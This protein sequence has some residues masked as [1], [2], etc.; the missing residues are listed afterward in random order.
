MC[1]NSSGSSTY[2]LPGHRESKVWDIDN[3]MT[4]RNLV[5]IYL[6]IGRGE[7]KRDYLVSLGERKKNRHQTE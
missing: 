6:L 7:G 4:Q 5:P 2:R 1:Q 3:S